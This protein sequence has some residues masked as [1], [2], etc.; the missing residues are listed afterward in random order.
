MST[1]FTD[2]TIKQA[3]V[4]QVKAAVK[5]NTIPDIWLNDTLTST[6]GIKKDKGK[7]VPLTKAQLIDALR[8]KISNFLVAMDNTS[9]LK[10]IK[11]FIKNGGDDMLKITIQEISTT[12]LLDEPTEQDIKD[13]N[14]RMMGLLSLPQ[15]WALLAKCNKFSYADYRRALA[16]KVMKKNNKKSTTSVKKTSDYISIPKD[17]A[18]ILI[19]EYYTNLASNASVTTP[20]CFRSAE[21][22]NPT[23][24]FGRFLYSTMFADK[25][26][27]PYNI[28]EKV[29]NIWKGKEQKRSL[30]EAEQVISS[31]TSANEDHLKNMF[32]KLNGKS[33]LTAI[34]KKVKDKDT[35]TEQAT[36]DTS[37]DMDDFMAEL[38]AEMKKEQA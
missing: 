34:M 32:A 2:I 3:V 31:Y 30:E 19:S 28:S 11:E 5:A 15:T 26:D 38:E 21:L 37:G 35:S 6:L 16:E 24:H 4:E 29:Y 27:S 1:V 17:E 23:Q 22:S 25:C 36:T 9:S 14:E 18:T 10:E 13:N 20:E 12:R 7:R 33:F 8:G